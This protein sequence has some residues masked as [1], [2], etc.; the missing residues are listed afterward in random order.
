MAETKS[1]SLPRRVKDLAG[2][3]FGRWTVIEF[4]PE[5]TSQ[6]HTPCWKCR[7]S[8]GTQRS[9]RGNNL[10][11]KK[12]PSLS[13]GCLNKE[14]SISAN[15]THG[16]SR[17]GAWRSLWHAIDRCYNK[18]HPAY[19]NYGGRGITVYQ[20]WIDSPE[21][22]LEYMGPRP[23]GMTIDRI[24]S[25]GNYEPGNCRWATN[26]E[27]HNNTRTNRLVSCN[28]ETLA[29]SEWARRMGVARITLSKRLD[30]GWSDEKAI[31]TPVRM[32]ARR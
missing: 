17:T 31:K 4:D 7:C 18:T 27:Q 3:V 26:V 21:K 32:K 24:D 15:T 10:T 30:A 5:T 19:E 25:N 12:K 9:V 16:L 22:F 13:C 1:T 6:K 29:V 14:R 2:Q 11:W 28:G 23:D 8:C 20:L